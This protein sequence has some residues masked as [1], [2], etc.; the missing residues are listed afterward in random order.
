MV[1]L[2]VGATGLLGRAT[3]L[4]MLK[5]GQRVRALVRSPER[6]RDLA[7]AGAE[8]VPGDLTD[9]ASLEQACKGAHRVFVCAHGL[10][11]RGAQSSV[12]VDHVG[13][14]ALI[15]IARAAGAARF[16]YTSAYGAREDHPIDF[17]R[18][19]YELEQALREGDMPFTILRPTAF[20]EQ[21]VHLFNGRMLLDKGFTV[22]V[23]PGNKPR[24]FVAVRDIVPFAVQALTT[25]T[26]EGRTID[27]GGPDHASNRE[28]ALMYSVRARQGKVHHLPLP[29]ARA[30]A[31]V[32]RPFHE[33]I[34]RVL[35]MALVP[36][37][38]WPETYDAQA[39]LAEFPSELTTLDQFIDERVREWRRSRVGRR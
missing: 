22:I 27:I 11:G 26:V 38:Q 37:D 10:L 17:F 2:I 23:G 35:D 24:N 19:K 15:A 25:D 32:V 34:A 39:Q 30:A 21:H 13:H 33:G 6:A 14:S 9:P 31:A 12:L 29:L 36:D 7:Q 5:E 1:V 8:L 18:T 28:V 4:A 16:V 20:M 3:T